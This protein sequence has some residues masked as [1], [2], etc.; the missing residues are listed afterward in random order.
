LI[1]RNVKGIG[2]GHVS[3]VIMQV[4]FAERGLRHRKLQSTRRESD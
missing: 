4:S 3:E 2:L 1:L